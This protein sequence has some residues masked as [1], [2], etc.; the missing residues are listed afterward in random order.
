M[1]DWS[2]RRSNKPTYARGVD[3]VANPYSKDSGMKIDWSSVFA[4]LA[5]AMLT[6]FILQIPQFLFLT[7]GFSEFSSPD[8]PVSFLHAPSQ[9]FQTPCCS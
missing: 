4:G 8:P 3:W 5:A 2:P 1:A 7:P 9:F 6:V